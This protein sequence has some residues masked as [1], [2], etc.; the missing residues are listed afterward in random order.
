LNRTKDE[1][2]KKEKMNE[3]LKKHNKYCE[4]NVRGGA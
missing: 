1:V 2:K 3:I 4:K